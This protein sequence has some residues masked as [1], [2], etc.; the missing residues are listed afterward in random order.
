MG[1]LIIELTNVTP[2]LVGW[3]EPE[4]IDPIGLRPTEIKGIWRWWARAF[5]GG[6][7][8]DAGLLR[9]ISSSNILRKPTWKEI[10]AISKI[11]GKKLGLGMAIGDLTMASRFKLYV[12]MTKSTGEVDIAQDHEHK[13]W[14]RI[15]LL[16]IRKKSKSPTDMNKEKHVKAW[17]PGCIFRLYIDYP[18]KDE[19]LLSTSLK[20]LLIA[21]QFNGIGKGS[22]RG[23]GSLDILSIS[24]SSKIIKSLQEYDNFYRLFE[25]TYQECEK[26]VH[27]EKE[28]VNMLSRIARRECGEEKTW[29]LPPMPVV[30]RSLIRPEE[31]IYVS[32]IRIY[33]L[34]KGPTISYNPFILFHNFFLR[35][36]R[37]KIITGT[38][39]CYDEIWQKKAGWFIGLPRSGKTRSGEMKG[40]IIVSRDVTRRAS[41]VCFSFH[42]EN[43]MFNKKVKCPTLHV[44]IFLS[45]DWPRRLKWFDSDD[46]NKMPLTVDDQAI[47]DAYKVFEYEFT[48]FILKLKINMKLDISVPQVIWPVPR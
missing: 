47:L 20:I 35:A 48:E 5:V 43:N 2:L 29:S 32:R 14:Q 1:R 11:I 9:G 15:R 26:I 8:Y 25:D 38:P 4:N 39:K 7:L 42:T 6:V 23:L 27:S 17:S 13:T 40:Y 16:T 41:P 22:R 10:T 31:K 30:S 36:E 18:D 12:E 34:N 37:C 45:G 21:L 3:Y 19:E 28:I 24:G 44:S 46:D 33:K